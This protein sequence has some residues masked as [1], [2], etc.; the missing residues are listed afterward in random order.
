MNKI[1]TLTSL[2]ILASL[3]QAL[4]Q[5]AAAI[6][7]SA[8]N[9][10]LTQTGKDSLTIKGSSSGLSADGAESVVLTAGPFRQQIG[11]HQFKRVKQVYSYTARKGQAGLSSL[12]LDF[13]KNRFSAKLQNQRLSG[14]TNPLAIGLTVG[15][16][17]AC[18]MLK[19][20]VKR[21]KWAFAEKNS[22]QFP[23]AIIAAPL[24]TPRGIWLDRA[25]PVT[26]RAEVTAAAAA[27]DNLSL[28]RI[29]DNLTPQGLP[30]CRLLDNGNSG[31]GDNT[32]N[33]RIYSCIADV[34]ASKAGSLN[35]LA[36]AEQGGKITYSPAFSLPVVV[37][38]NRQQAEETMA[39]QQASSQTWLDKLD[40]Y[41]DTRKARQ[42]AVAALKGLSGIDQ[43]TLSDDGNS[44]LLEFAGGVKGG[45]AFDRQTASITAAK[46]SALA[47]ANRLTTLAAQSGGEALPTTK[48]GNCRVM[49]WTPFAEKPDSLFSKP[50][51]I[52]LIFMK[53]QPNYFAF[54][55][56]YEHETNVAS[57]RTL[58]QYGT[59]ILETFSTQSWGG[60]VAYLT[61]EPLTLQTFGSEPYMLDL[62]TGSLEVW[63]WGASG[64]TGVW[65]YFFTPNFI[66]TLDDRFQDAIVLVISARSNELASALIGRNANAVLGFTV[67]QAD[68]ATTSWIRNAVPQ[69]LESLVDGKNS[70]EALA[71]V[72]KPA[73]IKAS[74]N[75]SVAANESA[76]IQFPQ[77]L[78][79]LT[80]A[81]GAEIK[82]TVT[83]NVRT[84]AIPPGCIPYRATARLL[85]DGSEAAT[86]EVTA[87][88]FS[89][90]F[91]AG[92]LKPGKHALSVELAF[93][94][95]HKLIASISVSKP[96]SQLD[97]SA[98]KSV[99]VELLAVNTRVE[100]V[101]FDNSVKIETENF[102]LG[103][104][105]CES[106]MRGAFS[107]TDYHAQWRDQ[108]AA[109]G[110]S[111]G[112]VT[113]T[114]DETGKTLLSFRSEV[115]T[116]GIGQYL[117]ANG[118]D[119]IEIADI[120][121]EQQIGK[122]L[123]YRLKGSEVCSHIDLLR[124]ESSA[125]QQQ[126]WTPYRSTRYVDAPQCS[127]F[128]DLRVKIETATGN[129]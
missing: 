97:M 110:L 22:P 80:P 98:Y 63:F 48:P 95:D 31:N 13:G 82:G 47:R 120:P 124:S 68:K 74:L 35:L 102:P 108:T 11:L 49:L 88:T 70:A 101:G 114:L 84:D 55:Q 91:D 121:F 17:S 127:N 128:S 15:A 107:G 4:A 119:S 52:E 44:V 113:A 5:S 60:Q 72:A 76:Y 65:Y 109:T 81:N 86:A 59:V 78:D 46:R 34:S 96:R 41:G 27:P 90:S 30:L 123:Y 43:A 111:S 118:Y 83:V 57:L 64:G 45:L 71:A 99:Y 25:T 12:V 51:P 89:L 92:S 93:S 3:P 10:V 33:D 112:D 53:P 56:L 40:Q 50:D 62:L 42:E 69:L 79:I 6:K 38:Y 66:S 100:Y 129:R 36:A 54:D 1:V 14:L 105:C 104:G 19:F 116:T 77:Q 7:V 28:Y 58:P 24:A 125:T 87:S 8:A 67:Q 18:S 61:S 29:D 106:Y 2:L 20:G 85:V 126:P 73:S 26:V 115:T 94:G 23:C 122:T 21:N 117:G 16:N 32:A 9:A 103:F 75:K 37:P 39:A